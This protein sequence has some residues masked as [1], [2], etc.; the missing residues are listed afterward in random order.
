MLV[1]VADFISRAESQSRQNLPVKKDTP[2]ASHPKVHNTPENTWDGRTFSG[3]SLLWLKQ[4]L[5]VVLV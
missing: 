2:Q 3:K 4:F 5:K 1:T